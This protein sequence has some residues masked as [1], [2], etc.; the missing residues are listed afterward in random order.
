MSLSGPM[1]L[2]LTG[3]HPC[4]YFDDREARDLVLDPA[5]P[6]LPRA[7]PSALA[8]GYR[9]SGAH[10][11]RPHCRQC[12]ACVPVRV[13]VAAFAPDRAQRRCLARNADIAMTD[14]AP[15]HT[16][17]RFALY[18]RYL[19]ARHAG[20]G[21]DA[22]APEDFDGF[23]AGTWSPTRFYEFRLDGRLV[24][25]AVTDV[26]RDALSAVYTFFEPTLAARGL[27]TLAI[28]RQIL[29]A[30]GTGRGHLYLGFWIAGHPKMDY[31][32]R[33]RPLEAL[34]DGT[35]R[36]LDPGKEG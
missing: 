7:Y 20:G 27:G 31:K 26:A 29:H 12:R 23:L 21:M 5:D 19:A 25:V 36:A 9:R 3:T 35:W 16:G 33:Y 2:Y 11:Y 8:Q 1:R 30:R 13:P 24:A 10:V 18:E 34:I 15:G 28:L 14:C 6:R 22:P 4:G 17:E 32:R